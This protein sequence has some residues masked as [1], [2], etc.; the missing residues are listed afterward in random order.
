MTLSAS[1]AVRTTTRADTSGSAETDEDGWRD[2]SGRGT[3]AGQARQDRRGGEP[4]SRGRRQ[5]RPGPG[6]GRRLPAALLPP[7]GRHRRQLALGG[8][9]ARAGRE[10]LPRR[11]APR[12]GPVGRA[13]PDAAAERRRLDRGRCDRRPGGHR[14]PALPRGLP[15]HGGAAAGLE[16]PRG[17]PPAVPGAP[18][19]HRRAA[20]RRAGGA[21]GGAG[22]AARVV[23]APG[24]P[25]APAERAP[26]GRSPPSSAVCR[27]CCGWSRSRSRTGSR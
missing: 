8:E 24:D 16:R 13:G 23:D 5:P 6:R 26:T 7:R 3:G 17:V 15:D 10:P 22:R 14:R 18:R 12:A 1:T 20:G 4:G 19:R 25:A 11:A 2:G 27:R 9:P 21:G